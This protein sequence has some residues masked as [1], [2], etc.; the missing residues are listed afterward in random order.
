MLLISSQFH[1]FLFYMCLLNIV[2]NLV[3]AFILKISKTTR[4]NTLYISFYI[5]YFLNVMYVYI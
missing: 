2:L 4:K 3:N 5:I 1:K